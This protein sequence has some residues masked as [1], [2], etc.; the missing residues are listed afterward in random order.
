V[1]GEPAACDASGSLPGALLTSLLSV[2]PAAEAARK[3]KQ[4]ATLADLAGRS[5]PV[6]R[7]E[8]IVSDAGQ[9]ARSYEEFLRIA[10]A[11][12]ALRGQALRR[13]GD[14]RLAEAEALA[15]GGEAQSAGAVDAARQAVAAYRQL[16]DEQPAYAGADAVLYQLARALDHGDEPDAALATLERLVREHPRSDHCA[17]AE[18]R[19][20]EAFF[21]AAR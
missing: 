7:G 21:S 20:G 5:V 13:L 1:G 19:R 17:E 15:A 6:Q 12:P 11:D 18:F 4:P 2:A 3:S 9:A 10:D 14:L 16:L 8:A